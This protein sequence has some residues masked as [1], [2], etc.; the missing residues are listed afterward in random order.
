ME[1]FSTYSTFCLWSFVVFVDA[2]FLTAYVPLKSCPDEC[3][4]Y[5]K[6][7][8]S[9]NSRYNPQPVRFFLSAFDPQYTATTDV[10]AKQPEIHFFVQ[11]SS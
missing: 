5:V 8:F 4:F 9:D 3:R 2:A 6:R 1:D 10:T 11:R 7:T